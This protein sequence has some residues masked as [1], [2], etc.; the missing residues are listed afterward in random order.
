[1]I[2]SENQQ[3]KD[4]LK[5]S[6][7]VGKQINSKSE[8]DRWLVERYL[9]LQETRKSID[10][11]EIHHIEW[12]TFDLDVEQLEIEYPRFRKLLVDTPALG[13]FSPGVQVL[14]WKKKKNKI[15]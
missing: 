5:L 8:I 2:Y 11:F 10:E 15:C 1:M 13:H 4:K 3:F 12:P 9:L 7:E 14:A 6:Y